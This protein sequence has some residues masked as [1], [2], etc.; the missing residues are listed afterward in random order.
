M[1]CRANKNREYFVLLPSNLTTSMSFGKPWQTSRKKTQRSRRG[2][3]QDE[4]TQQWFLKM[5]WFSVHVLMKFY[6]L[7]PEKNLWRQCS[8]ILSL[9]NGASICTQTYKP[10]ILKRFIYIHMYKLFESSLYINNC[11][12]LYEVGI[13]WYNI[14]IVMRI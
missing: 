1:L 11:I 4:T 14:K 10:T 5:I 6:D 3:C 9:G 13:T 8:D 7:Y 2:H 12:Y